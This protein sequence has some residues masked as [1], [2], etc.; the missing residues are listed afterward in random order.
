M[1]SFNKGRGQ[2]MMVSEFLTPAGN[3]WLSED[4]PEEDWPREPD[5]DPSRECTQ[6]RDFFLEKAV[7]GRATT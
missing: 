7:I 4:I 2:G 5:G 1:P 3:L 6:V